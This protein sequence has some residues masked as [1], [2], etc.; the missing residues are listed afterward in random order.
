VVLF[1]D[2]GEFGVR[3]EIG[4]GSSV[5]VACVLC[6]VVCCV[7]CVLGKG[8]WV[9]LCGV[10]C[11]CV[12]LLLVRSKKRVERRRGDNAQIQEQRADMC[13]MGVGLATN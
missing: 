1:F 10:A 3:S 9:V 12:G 4:S 6:C 2:F 7:V 13:V 8:C 5:L 11:L